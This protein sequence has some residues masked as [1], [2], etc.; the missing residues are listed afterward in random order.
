MSYHYVSINNMRTFYPMNFGMYVAPMPMFN[1]YS[2][3][4]PFAVFSTAMSLMQNVFPSLANY[5][6]P[7]QSNYTNFGTMPFW[8]NSFNSG[9]YG[10]FNSMNYPVF[11]FSNNFDIP[12][13]ELPK[14][15]NSDTFRSK[16]T[17]SE[18]PI[19]KLP[20]HKKS[21]KPIDDV[22][23]KEFNKSQYKPI[24]STLYGKHLNRA[25]L[26]KVK[27]VAKNINCDYEDLLAVMN[28]ESGLNPAIPH[29]NS[30]GEKTAVGLIQFTKNGAIAELNKSYGMDLTIE[31]IEKMS[32]IEQLDLVEKYYKIATKKFGGKKLTA[33]DLYAVTYVPAFATRDI[34]TRKGDGYYEGNEGLD[35]NKDGF[36]TK[37]DLNIRLAK[38]RVNLDTFV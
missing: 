12:T 38:K 2:Y 15:A 31:K 21:T 6:N 32:A 3:Y 19:I 33:A 29:R 17:T 37:E 10:S 30:K 27:Q 14:A 20:D 1:C 23:P 16:N 8:G 26:E 13:F 18:F 25:F 24:Y 9:Y 36:I 5:S 11:N 7:F 35:E 22:A 34:L 4:N 28:S